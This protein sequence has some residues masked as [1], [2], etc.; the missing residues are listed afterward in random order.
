MGFTP[1]DSYRFIIEFLWELLLDY[2]EQF[3]LKN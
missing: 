3:N 1:P 2:I